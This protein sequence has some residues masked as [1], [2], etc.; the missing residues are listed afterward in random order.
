M[1]VY[2]A[3]NKSVKDAEAKRIDAVLAVDLIICKLG[4]PA[5][6]DRPCHLSLYHVIGN[7]LL[8]ECLLVMFSSSEFLK[9]RANQLQY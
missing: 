1:I 3:M 4:H 8:Q 7:E 2:V 5:L 6:A 9:S